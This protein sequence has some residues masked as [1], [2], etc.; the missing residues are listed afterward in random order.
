MELLHYTTIS[1]EL[2]TVTKKTKHNP[3]LLSHYS[4][5]TFCF[6]VQWFAIAKPICNLERLLYCIQEQEPE[7][8][9]RYLFGS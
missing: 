1:A 8:R 2:P 4:D 9:N 5:W 6:S 3:F 7:N